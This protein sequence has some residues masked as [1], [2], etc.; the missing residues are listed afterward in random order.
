MGFEV[1]AL[2]FR[3]VG[4]RKASW[5]KMLPPRMTLTWFQSRNVEVELGSKTS[6]LSVLAP[7]LVPLCQ[8]H[9][10]PGVECRLHWCYPRTSRHFPWQDLFLLR[11]FVLF[12]GIDFLVILLF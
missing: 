5:E 10:G 4:G 12:C 11:V 8:V 9:I 1:Q 6:T 7:N 2:D 3:C